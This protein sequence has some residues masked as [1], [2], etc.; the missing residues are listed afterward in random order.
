MPANALD[1]GQANPDG[2]RTLKIAGSNPY[3]EY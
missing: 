2:L 1:A 3:K